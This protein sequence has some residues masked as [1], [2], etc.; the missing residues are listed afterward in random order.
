MKTPINTVVP[1][2][3]KTLPASEFNGRNRV[4]SGVEIPGSAIELSD[5]PDLALEV[6]PVAIMLYSRFFLLSVI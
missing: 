2:P 3:G 6:V 1:Q 4:P 5:T